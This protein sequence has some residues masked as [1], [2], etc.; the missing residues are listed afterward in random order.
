MIKV[1]L[2]FIDSIILSILGILKFSIVSHALVTNS[3]YVSLTKFSSI[4]CSRSVLVTKAKNFSM[5]LRFGE[6]RTWY[7]KYKCTNIF[8]LFWNF[9]ERSHPLKFFDQMNQCFCQKLQTQ[10]FL[11][12]GPFYQLS[13]LFHSDS[14]EQHIYYEKCLS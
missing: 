10:Q 7:F 4:T 9:D 1:F 3:S 5:R 12:S 6:R 8:H 13:V 14:I 2:L 11:L